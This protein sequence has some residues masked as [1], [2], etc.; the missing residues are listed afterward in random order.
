[1]NR[2]F[3]HL[4]A[5]CLLSAPIAGLCNSQD[6]GYLETFP[7]QS[8]ALKITVADQPVRSIACSDVR[9]ETIV[10]V[11]ERDSL[12]FRHPLYR[13][14]QDKLV[15]RHPIYRPDIDRA[16]IYDLEH[17]PGTLGTLEPAYNMKLSGIESTSNSNR[18]T[19]RIEDIDPCDL[20][21]PVGSERRDAKCAS[22]EEGS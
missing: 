6:P 15:I 5:L 21:P 7:R 8:P 14:G 10:Y 1:M 11:P 17:A 22:G 4:L 16:G 20:P 2:T 18:G 9:T 12:S 19:L 13:P 3:V